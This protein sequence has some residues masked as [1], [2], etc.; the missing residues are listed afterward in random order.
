[1][2]QEN[3]S[4]LLFGKNGAQ[5]LQKFLNQPRIDELANKKIIGIFDFDAQ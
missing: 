3:S 4:F 5:N 1:L 2:F